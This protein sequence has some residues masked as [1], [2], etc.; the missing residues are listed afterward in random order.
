MA[1]FENS[2]ENQ[3]MGHSKEVVHSLSKILLDKIKHRKQSKIHCLKFKKNDNSELVLGG[4]WQDQWIFLVV[5]VADSTT[6]M[7]LNHFS[8]YPE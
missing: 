7:T 8:E 5:D 4:S 2:F 3:H 1:L 6:L